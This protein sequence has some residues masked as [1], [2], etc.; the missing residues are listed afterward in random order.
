MDLNST[1][2]RFTSGGYFH[3]IK[4]PGRHMKWGEGGQ[5][6][7]FM[8]T[9]IIL[10]KAPICHKLLVKVDHNVRIFGYE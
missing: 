3:S 1:P 2:S 8:H 10:C 5:Q 6:N 9:F 7:N 4:L